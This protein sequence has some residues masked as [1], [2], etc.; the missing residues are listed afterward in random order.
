M[1]GINGAEFLIILLVFVVVVEPKDLPKMLKAI[2]KMKEYLR[3]VISEFRYQLDDAIKEVDLD[4]LQEIPRN[5]DK[6]SS[7]KKSKKVPNPI[8]DVTE[9]FHDPLVTDVTAPTE[10]K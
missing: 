2:V 4:N 10:E 8:Q 6:L 9:G 3:S 5:I 1:F 7:Q